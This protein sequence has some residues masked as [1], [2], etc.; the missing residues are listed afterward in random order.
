LYERTTRSR[1]L[2]EEELQSSHEPTRKGND[3][4]I[5]ASITDQM[6]PRSF[7]ELV[8][9]GLNADFPD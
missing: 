3:G 9:F 6:Q 1:A 2:I 7:E 5:L 4:G 8:K